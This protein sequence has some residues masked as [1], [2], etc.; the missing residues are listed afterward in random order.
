MIFLQ[1]Q[2]PEMAD[3][4]RSEGKI[5]IVVG[6]MLISLIGVLGYLIYLDRKISNLEKNK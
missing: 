1:S 2:A 6:V 5:Y 4:L 3:I